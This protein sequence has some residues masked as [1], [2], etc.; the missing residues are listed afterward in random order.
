VSVTI[1][2]AD[3]HQVDAAIGFGTIEC[4]RTEASWLSRSFGGGAR[5]LLLSGSV[6]RIGIGGRT[7]SG[8]GRSLCR[9]DNT[10][11][12]KV[13]YR[14]G[15]D[16]TQP[17]FLSPR[18]QV[19]LSIAAE[20]ESEPGIFQRESRGGRIGLNRR[21]ADRTFVTAAFNAERG[22][23]LASPALY[24][25]AFLV[26]Q[27]GVTDSLSRTR[28]RDDVELSI[29]HDATDLPVDPT[30]GLNVSAALNWAAEPLGSEIS[31]F[32]MS[33]QGGFYRELQPG[34]VAAIGVRL[35]NF[36]RSAS[37]DPS[38]NFLP[39]QE[40][41][42]AGGSNSV[43]GYDR[44]ALGEGL[45]VT[46]AVDT[47]DSGDVVPAEGQGVT[48]TPIGGTSLAITSAELRFPSPLLSEFMR[49]AVFVDGGAVG[50]G[51]LW[52]LSPRDWRFTPGAGLRLQTP[53]GPVRFDVAYNPYGATAGPLLVSDDELV[54][55]TRVSD[56]YRPDQSFLSRFHITLGIGQAY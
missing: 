31:F 10:F 7:A 30:N 48:F 4:L 34:W 2:E 39:P 53:V 32:R 52:D 14:F 28:F 16:L 6:S 21:L 37:L 12:S 36:F 45:Y 41:F 29:V 20:R 44:N 43:R 50:T 22:R 51:S 46:G 56:S 15:A 9:T 25:V 35:G 42:F 11:E 33:A 23:T 5:R 54:T 55:L 8:I 18:N 1:A 27:V 40:R 24:C 19:S 49:L 26:C 13:D 17:Y 3:V 47:T 38:H